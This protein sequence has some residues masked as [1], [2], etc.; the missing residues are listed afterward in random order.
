MG[1]T[2]VG[3]INRSSNKTAKY[4]EIIA[5]LSKT[6]DHYQEIGDKENADLTQRVIDYVDKRMDEI[7]FNKV[8]ATGV[9]VGKKIETKTT[10]T[11]KTD[12]GDE[13]TEVEE[14]NGLIQRPETQL[15]AD[16]N[17]MKSEAWKEEDI[18][19]IQP[20]D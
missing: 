2:F 9:K 10:L 1:G 4:S 15:I 7:L 13:F 5:Q 17:R 16:L 11:T 18:T 6:L 19:K 12:I 20:S 8:G 3:A 14:I